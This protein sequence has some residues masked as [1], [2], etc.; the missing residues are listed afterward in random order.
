MRRDGRKSDFWTPP[1]GKVLS[2]ARPYMHATKKDRGERVTNENVHGCRFQTGP[3]PDGLG[4]RPGEREARRRDLVRFGVLYCGAFIQR[5]LSDR[6]VKV[7]RKLE[8]LVSTG[9]EVCI[10]PPRL[11]EGFCGVV[12][13]EKGEQ[14]EINRK[15]D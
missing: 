1:P 5:P 7:I 14:N 15:N 13:R 8:N 4:R 10:R 11:V 2:A 9:G 3:G 12:P 6:M